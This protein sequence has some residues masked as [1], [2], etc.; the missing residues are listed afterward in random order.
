MFLNI[1]HAVERPR[2]CFGS[3]GAN[4]TDSSDLRGRLSVSATSDP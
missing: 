2:R 3:R 4:V 1:L